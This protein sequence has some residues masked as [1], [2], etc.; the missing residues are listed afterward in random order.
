GIHTVASLEA[1]LA[2]CP[3]VTFVC[4]PSSEH[5]PVAL[6]AVRAGSHVFVEKPLSADL[7]GVDELIEEAARRD[8][9][10]CVGYQLRFHPALRE[11]GRLVN[12]GSLG[13]IL[14]IRA[15]VGEYLPN[16]HRYEDYREMY[17]SRRELGGGVILSQIHELDYL[18]MLFGMP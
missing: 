15:Q 3:D 12:S 14:S 17:A 18:I 1:G 11:L 9:V 7:N 4:N 8:R 5:V 13:H 10:G 6:A 2:E 16:F